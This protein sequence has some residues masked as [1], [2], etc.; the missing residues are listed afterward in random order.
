MLV[1]DLLAYLDIFSI[2]LL[3]SVVGRVSALLYVARQVAARALG[4]ISLARQRLRR[5]D[6]RRQSQTRSTGRPPVQTKTEDDGV[7][8]FGL[9]WA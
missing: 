7:P 5:P 6:S 8:V 4:L 9:A 1:G 3:L 2:L